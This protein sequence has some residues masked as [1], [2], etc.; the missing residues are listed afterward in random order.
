MAR[1]S[2]AGACFGKT[3][4]GDGDGGATVE[5][6]TLMKDVVGDRLG[7]KAAGGIRTYGDAMALIEAGASRLG[8]SAGLRIIEDAS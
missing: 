8:T 6:V 2:G 1:G 7:I 3:S 4:T 5:D